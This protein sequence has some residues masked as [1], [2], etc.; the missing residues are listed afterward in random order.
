MKI[1]TKIQLIF[2]G[3]VIV[4]MFIVGILASLLSYDAL[5]ERVNDS[6]I[7]SAKL[8]TD[9][10]SN[11]LKNYM[12]AVTIAGKDSTLSTKGNLSAKKALVEQ[13]VKDYGF[14]S[15]N[16]LNEKGV[17]LLDGTD[18]SDRD[19]VQKALAGTVNV[20]DVTLSKY[21]NTYGVSIAAPIEA[22]SGKVSGVVYF[23][24]DTDFMNS[25]VKNISVSDNSY[26]YIL[27]ENSY[28]IVHKDE[29]KIMND[30]VKEKEAAA[31]KAIPGKKAGNTSYQQ[32]GKNILCGY[33]PIENTNGWALVI[34]APETDYSTTIVSMVK[35]FV[36]C[37]VAAVIIALMIAA[38]L[39]V[40]ISRS[41]KMVQNSLVAVSGGDFSKKIPKTKRKDEIGVLQNAASDL[42]DTL[43]E[44]IGE[45]NQ[46]LGGIAQY[47]LTQPAMKT[48]PGAFDSLSKSINQIRLI[49]NQL[50]SELQISSVNVESGSKQLA[51]A[52]ELLSEGSMRQATSIQSLV[53]DIENI[54]ESINR[55]SDNENMIN[56]K[57]NSLDEEI[58]DSD[59]Q[60]SE[61]LQV[62]REV[63]EMSEDIQKIVSTID[64]IAFQTNILA[65]NASVEAARAGENGKGFAV[66]AEEVSK[67]AAKSSEASKKTGDLIEKCIQSI[68]NAKECADATFDSLRKIVGD[69]DEIAQAFRDI[70]ADTHREAEKANSIR[71]E[72]GNINS[73]V[74]SNTATAEQT[75][76]S[77]EVL[78]NQAF[79]LEQMTAK[80]KVENNTVAGISQNYS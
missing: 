28:V 17:S 37:D 1:A 20:S 70:S 4:L 62:V 77:T 47:D 44:I 72:L 2:G 21:T 27:D 33:A 11:Q 29:K 31:V 75:A 15:G 51:E 12:T 45:A 14:T 3:T 52:A 18:F 46:V 48:Y 49:L 53:T 50:I 13:Y 35:K 24:L 7:S 10:I 30:D 61:L 74:Q 64:S 32:S 56:G 9:D 43:S 26:A 38:L 23:R 69:S 5:I 66:V 65:L 8:A 73:V 16:I 79:S 68:A 67:L 40:S 19:Y 80:F 78:S 42:L 25:I 54:V 55:S 36:A 63:E 41:L 6:M 58:K 59:T 22:G 60:M 76:A 34:A 71:G 39:A 57:L